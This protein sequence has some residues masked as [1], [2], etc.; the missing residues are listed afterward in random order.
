MSA[1]G[2]IE[3]YHPEIS[4]SLGTEPEEPAPGEL[5]PRLELHPE[6]EARTN[7]GGGGALCLKAFADSVCHS[8]S[9]SL[10]M[11]FSVWSSDSD[12]I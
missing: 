1:S 2:M 4:E 8:S 11:L 9:E 5:E 12:G 10:S 6:P 7:R 3:R